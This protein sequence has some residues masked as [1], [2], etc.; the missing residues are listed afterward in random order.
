L[1]LAGSAVRPAIQFEFAAG[2][3]QEVI[4]EVVSIARHRASRLDGEF[5]V[6]DSWLV[7]V[8]ACPGGFAC[9]V[10]VER[11]RRALHITARNTKAGRGVSDAF[12]AIA[13][14]PARRAH[15]HASRLA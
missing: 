13:I 7:A 3:A 5:G 11:P 1:L 9:T 6:P 8:E 12:D 15:A 14:R 10:I 4:I 2:T